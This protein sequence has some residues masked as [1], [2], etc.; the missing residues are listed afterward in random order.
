MDVI[1][2]KLCDNGITI[3]IGSAGFIDDP[4]LPRVCEKCI[5]RLGPADGDHCTRGDREQR[6]MPSGIR[7]QYKCLAEVA[8]RTER[9]VLLESDSNGQ[10]DSAGIQQIHVDPIHAGADIISEPLIAIEGREPAA[11]ASAADGRDLEVMISSSA[12]SA[13]RDVH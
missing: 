6:V 4:Q 10:R 12:G 8:W 9:N 13:V 2:A 5:K 11:W 1:D 3:E 7:R